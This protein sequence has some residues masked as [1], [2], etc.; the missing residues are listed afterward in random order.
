[1]AALVYAG[2]TLLRIPSPTGGYT[3][4]GDAF[5]LLSGWL[6][7]PWWGM[8]AAGMGSALAELI[9]YP[10][11]IL[12]SLLIKGAMGFLS[13]W[14]LKKAGSRFGSLAGGIAAE[15]WMCVG[16]FLVA[17]LIFGKGTAALASVPGNLLQG[18]VGIL[19]GLT[20][21]RILKKALKEEFP[22]A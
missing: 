6:L 22:E 2:T 14:I 19:L 13:G 5:V 1:M 9:G 20:L 18:G 8:A 11:Y 12:P 15:L 3:H 4:L 7:G 10:L 16:Y 21:F 17:A